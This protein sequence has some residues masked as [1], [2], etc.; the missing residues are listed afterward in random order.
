MATNQVLD[1]KELTLAAV[2]AAAG[3]LLA[4]YGNPVVLIASMYVLFYLLSKVFA[5]NEFGEIAGKL[6]L[7]NAFLEL[8]KLS[9]TQ[10]WISWYGPQ[11]LTSLV[12]YTK[13]LDAVESTLTIIAVV[14][15]IEAV[16]AKKF[17]ESQKQ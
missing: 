8:I 11:K 13:Y 2:I 6:L 10:L 12:N 1:W 7:F 4:M 15:L 5:K 17:A 3:F 9:L 16:V 14:V